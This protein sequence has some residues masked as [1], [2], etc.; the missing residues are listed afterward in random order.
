MFDTKTC[1]ANHSKNGQAK[2]KRIKEKRKNKITTI[3]EEILSLT[4][5]DKPYTDAETRG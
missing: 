4:T 5:P 3:D 2:K 1:V